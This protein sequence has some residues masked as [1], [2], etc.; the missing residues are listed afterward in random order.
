MNGV[1]EQRAPAD[2]LNPCAAGTH[3]TRPV[4][5][6]N[7]KEKVKMLHALEG[8]KKIEHWQGPTTPGDG[9]G[10]RIRKTT[11]LHGHARK[12]SDLGTRSSGNQA[13]PV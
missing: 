10:H 11:G 6:R 9:G 1:T 7:G 12:Q 8:L 5:R 3:Y 13:R 2:R 4:S